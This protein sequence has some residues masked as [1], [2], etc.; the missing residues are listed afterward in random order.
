MRSSLIKTHYGWIIVFAGILTLFAC[1][2]L[3]RFTLGMLLPSMGETLNLTYSQMGLIS[4]FNFI[5]YLAAVVLVHLLVERIG[6]RHTVAISLLLIGLSMAMISF[7]QGFYSILFLYL[8]TGIASGGANVP[9]MGLVSHWFRRDLRGKAAG[10]M[11]IGNGLAIMLTGIMVPMINLAQG[12]QGWR[13]SWLIM[14]G[15]VIAIAVIAEILLRNS[16]EEMGLMPLGRHSDF[17]QQ[18]AK[19]DEKERRKIV[20]HIGS[21]YF[22]FGFSYVIYATFIVTTLVN[23]RNMSEAFAGNIWFWIGFFSLFSG[24]LFGTLSDK[25]GRKAGLSLV[26]LLH[27]ISYLLIGVFNSEWA[28]YVSVFLFGI[29]AWSVPSIMAATTGDYMG[30]EHAVKAFGTVTLF[31]G[32]GQIIGPTL[33][34]LIAESSGSFV[35]SYL[36]AALFSSFAIVLLHFLRKAH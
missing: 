9:I 24:P 30:P 35:S 1:L 31:F 7:G 25:L 13:L 36:M 10:Y 33:A 32:M 27:V 29:C 8:I 34:G 12:A 28:V 22:M 18:H 5:G 6:T 4:T 14:G 19:S 11:V 20:I 23:E 21:I 2:G 26:Y 17:H 3:G 15:I 16:P